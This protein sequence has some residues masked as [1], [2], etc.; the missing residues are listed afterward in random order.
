MLEKE[1]AK[2]ARQKSDA[3]ERKF[4]EQNDYR[5]Y[6]D[7]QRIKGLVPPD[8]TSAIPTSLDDSS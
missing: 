5:P 8:M 7:E 4:A 6:Q 1:A 2:I 3:D